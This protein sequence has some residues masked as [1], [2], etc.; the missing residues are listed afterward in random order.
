MNKYYLKL[1]RKGKQPHSEKLIGQS[2]IDFIVY[3]S[4]KVEKIFSIILILSVLCIPFVQVNYDLSK[5]LPSDMPSKQGIDLMEKEFGYPGSAR[6]MIRD[7]SI[8]EAKNYKDRIENITGVEQVIWADSVTD[9]YQAKF[10]LPYENIKDY[11]RNGCAA[12]DVMFTEGDSSA[13][14]RAALVEIKNML[15]DKAA[16]SGPAVQS[17]YQNE[18]LSREM[19]SIL[20]FGIVIILAILTMFTHSWFEPIV[21]I[22][23]ILI[24][25]VINMGTNVFFGSISSI[26]LS[27]AAVLQLAIAMD[28]TIILLDNFT[29]ERKK[30][31]SVEVSLSNAIRKSIT[32]VA[33]AGIAA[34]VGFS[35]LVLMRYSI[36]RDIGLVLTKGI[37]IS[38]ITVMFLT[39]A[40]LQRSYRLIEKTQHRYII[41]GFETAASKIH[42]FRKPIVLILIVLAVP[43]YF[44]KDM[45]DF[46]FGNDAMGLSKGTAVYNDYQ[47]INSAFG[48]KNLIIAIVPNETLVTERAFSK[49]LESLPYVKDVTSLASSI[50]AGVPENFVPSDI[51]NQFHTENYSRILI[52]VVTANES[53]LAFEAVDTIR[54]IEK[55]YYGD[56]GYVVG[57]TPSTMDIKSVIVDDW[58]KI[59][60]ISII[61]VALAIMI[62]FRSFVLP[63]V[64]IIPIEVAIFINM[65]IPY[66]AG[67]RIMFMGYIICSCLQL[68]ATIDYSIVMTYH[69]L[70]SRK[71]MDKTSA[72]I[73]A[74]SDSMPPILMSGLILSVAG[75]GVYFLSSISAI[76]E[77]GILIGR[78]ALMSMIMVIALLPSLF[79]WADK[80]IV[81]KD[82]VKNKSRRY[83]V[84]ETEI[85]E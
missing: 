18:I 74:T 11:Y 66:L 85:S 65:M 15:G 34:I 44:G 61:G 23:V 56:Q 2:L 73:K 83:P 50:P 3:K 9:I 64:L 67:D 40:V 27:V 28:Y 77:L 1:I 49:E 37:A 12:M 14:T 26:T 72:S 47:E 20:I 36:G 63:F 17:K 39:P 54:N 62:A 60:K 43:S 53:D 4:K 71:I 46:T 30:L 7:V 58:S 52:P 6:V 55:K 35:V 82:R 19:L 70:E 33:S 45:T 21:F 76:S 51:K 79:I 41:P 42:K 24:S 57:G 68:G 78:G 75:F 80:W 8:Y 32:P 59:E 13:G 16:M 5:Y 48:R 38:L 31:L 25:V 69:Y 22:T 29:K 81:N 84:C 10:F